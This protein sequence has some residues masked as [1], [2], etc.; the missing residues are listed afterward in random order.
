MKEQVNFYK[1]NWWMY[2]VGG[3]ATL[4]FG[5]IAVMHPALTFIS[6][7]FF[8]GLYLLI[9]GVVDIITALSGCKAKKSWI[10]GLIFG[11][12]QALIGIYLIQRPGLAFATFI[13]FVALSLLIRGVAHFIEFFDSSYDAVYRTW[14]AIAGVVSILA[15]I[16]VWRYPVQGTLAFVW[17]IGVF[18]IINGPLMIAFAL[19]AK[20]GFK[21]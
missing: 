16:I 7:A 11:G 5:I 6:L 17:V 13:I 21:K 2:L 18:A 8:F 4:L 12:L 19:E 14:Q 3:L 20:R 9:V 10:F 15:S 1:Q